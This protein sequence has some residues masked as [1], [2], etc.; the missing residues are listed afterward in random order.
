[1]GRHSQAEGPV[2]QDGASSQAAES[3]RAA[4]KSRSQ[5]SRKMRAR[6]PSQTPA[7]AQSPVMSW[8]LILV[9]LLGGLASLLAWN[10]RTQ[11]DDWASLWVGGLLM[12]R[13][14]ESHLYDADPIDFLSLIHI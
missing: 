14:L 5:V 10:G 1:M 11:P 12:D 6:K 3:Q 8:P 4:A 9:S 7:L 2:S 13:G